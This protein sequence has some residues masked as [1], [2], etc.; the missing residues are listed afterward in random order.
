MVIANAENGASALVFTTLLVFCLASCVLKAQGCMPM[1]PM[2]S[3]SSLVQQTANGF[4][5]QAAT[6][7]FT[8]F[9]TYVGEP[10]M[11]LIFFGPTSLVSHVL[12]E[13]TPIPFSSQNITRDALRTVNAF[14]N[15]FNVIVR[16]VETFIT[17]ISEVARINVWTFLSSKIRLMYSTHL[18]LAENLTASY[19][20]SQMNGL[21]YEAVDDQVSLRVREMTNREGKASKT[22]NLSMAAPALCV[23]LNLTVSLILW[24]FCW[25]V[26]KFHT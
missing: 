14:F 9:M 1:M 23:F 7:I 12:F 8:P 17:V 2:M 15:W 24:R 3:V 10:L 22:E 11:R 4:L 13:M 20:I 5:Y 6:Q 19:A 16:L 26:R 25:S 21:G 18:L